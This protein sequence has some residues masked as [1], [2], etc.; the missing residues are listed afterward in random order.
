MNK[1]PSIKAI[2][3][4]PSI[5]EGYTFQDL[6]TIGRV[7]A[8]DATETCISY[9]QKEYLA[10]YGM[11]QSIDEA[12]KSV[13]AWQKLEGHVERKFKEAEAIAAIL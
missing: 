13:E 4:L 11:P 6:V 2:I 12:S 1:L 7:S 5:F 8:K 9:A 10:R 3:N